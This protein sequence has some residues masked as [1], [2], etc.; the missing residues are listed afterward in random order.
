MMVSEFIKLTGFEPT[1]DEYK[2]IEEEYYKYEGDKQQ[3]CKM[4]IDNGG[5]QKICRERVAKINGLERQLSETLQENKALKAELDK[6]M[7]W[8]PCEGGTNFS[9]EQYNT[10]AECPDTTVLSEVE[11]KDLLYKEFGFAPDKIIIIKTV[12]T[13]EANRHHRMRKAESYD[14]KPLYNATDWN[15]I[16]FDCAGWMYE[17]VNGSLKHYEC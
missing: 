17:M 15:Y 7:E 6:E 9:Q 2:Q 8:K 11:A 14:R 10:L 16:R 13:Y 1:T 3:F 12:N 5:I 4:F